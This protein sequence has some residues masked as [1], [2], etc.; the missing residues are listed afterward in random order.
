M[1][2]I[3]FEDKINSILDKLGSSIVT[4]KVGTTD[5]YIL[6]NTTDVIHFAKNSTLLD[7]PAIKVEGKASFYYDSSVA[8]TPVAS[9][10]CTYGAAVGSYTNIFNLLS[11]GAF[12]RAPARSADLNISDISIK[13]NIVDTAPKLH[14][15]MRIS[16]RDFNFKESQE[17]WTGFIA[18]EVEEVF[19][20][21]VSA[22]NINDQN[23]KAIK[24]ELFIPI[25][26]KSL[27]EL[28]SELNNLRQR[29]FVLESR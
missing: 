6:N 17:K 4:T 23:Y 26:I 9:F 14:D 21:L 16:V 27:Q 5:L 3:T 28:Y 25:T 24:T 2:Q 22:V 13:E 1:A 15:L 12:A 10:Y 20:N 18:Q 29:I 7:L 19:P 8:T 11:D